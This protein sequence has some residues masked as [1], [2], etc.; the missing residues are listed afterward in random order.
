MGEK[1]VVVHKSTIEEWSRRIEPPLP[2]DMI[3][4]VLQR[5]E[6]M[7]RQFEP[8]HVVVVE[9]SLS[10]GFASLPE[11]VGLGSSVILEGA[12][13]GLCLRAARTVLEENGI[14]VTLDPEGCLP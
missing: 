9:G 11:R 10:T 7:T 13:A 8:E 12:R 4:G 5:I 14:Q 2:R 3:Q 1:L 6:Y